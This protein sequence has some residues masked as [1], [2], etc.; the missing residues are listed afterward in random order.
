MLEIL[1]IFAMVIIVVII[2]AFMLHIS[3]KIFKVTGASLK[4]AL[5]IT[6]LLL[7]ISSIAG[8]AAGVVLTVSGL[9][10]FV[11]LFSIIIG[12]VVFHKLLQ[13]YYKTNLRRNIAIYL[14]YTV[15]S[16]LSV[17]IIIFPIRSYLAEPFFMSGASMEQ[18]YKNG[19]YLLINKFDRNYNRGDVIVFRY[20][21]NPNELMIKRIIGLP[22]EKISIKDNKITV[23]NNENKNG[24]ILD[25]TDYI[26]DGNIT[27]G[28]IEE[29]LKNDE[30][31]VLGDNRKASADSRY[32]GALQKHFIVGKV[33][34]KVK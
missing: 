2:S 21:R 19:D 25:E 8:I 23:S 34:F 13:R 9:Q 16:I 27:N 4:T 20:P 33:L 7:V 17:F 32:W 26:T 1:L 3:T 14:V 18:T 6:I 31:Y 22:G 30:Y 15:I 29:E 11:S 12:F 5:I 24:F 10:D 28:D